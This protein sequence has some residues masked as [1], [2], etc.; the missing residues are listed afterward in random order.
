MKNKIK[1]ILLLIFAVLFV[2]SAISGCAGKTKYFKELKAAYSYDKYSCVLK[3]FPSE[4]NWQPNE[5]I[6]Y[7]PQNKK[8]TVLKYETLE[9]TLPKTDI[10]T[11]K[12]SDYKITMAYAVYNGKLVFTEVP[13]HYLP[14][15]YYIIEGSTDSVVVAVDD[16]AF[17]VNLNDGSF[18]KLLYE[19][20]EEYNINKTIEE[21]YVY[22]FQNPNISVSDILSGETFAVNAGKYTDVWNVKLSDSKEYL[23]FFGSYIDSQNSLVA[24]I[25]TLNI[26]TNAIVAHY[27]QKENEYRID[28]FDS[29]GWC[30]DNVLYVNFINTVNLNADLC[31]LH[32]ITH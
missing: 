22:A 2:V 13:L 15:D 23:A 30:P 21:Q 20:F 8:T 26:K 18:K 4:I 16:E 14:H 9:V 11:G 17:L 3:K 6:A 10:D 27:Y 25:V 7:N 24:E 32:K 12:I 28:S 5:L 19:E 29:F 1:R 31:R